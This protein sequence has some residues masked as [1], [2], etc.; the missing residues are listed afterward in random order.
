MLRIFS[1]AGSFNGEKSHTKRASD[2]LAEAVIRKAAEE[3][4]EVSYECMTADQLRIEHCRG[5]ASCFKTG[6]C[7][8]DRTEDMPLLKQKQIGRAHV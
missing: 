8:L 4:I 5:C 3:G 7:P 1:F 6:I 2:M